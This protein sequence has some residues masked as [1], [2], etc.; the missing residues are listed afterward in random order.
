MPHR[1]R[2]SDDV[3]DR[4]LAGEASLAETQAVEAWLAADPGRARAV[5]LLRGDLTGTWDANEGWRRLNAR[6]VEHMTGDD[7]SRSRQPVWAAS[8]LLI[9]FA[10]L[11]LAV[12]FIAVTRS[13]SHSA[14]NSQA[15]Q[16]ATTAAAPGARNLVQLGEATAFLGPSTSLRYSRGKEEAEL[17]GAA[18]FTTLSSQSNLVVRAGNVIK[19]DGETQFVVRADSGRDVVIGA[20][21]GTIKV[22]G[23]GI[24]DTVT[25]SP[26]EMVRVKQGGTAAV[27]R[28]VDPAVFLG[29]AKLPATA[30]TQ[31]EN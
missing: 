10:L 29:W 20:I 15:M 16:W 12:G 1:S 18:L 3:L 28:D 31:R 8:P 23:P 7:S 25:L 24:R 4:Y 26:R 21:A 9:G 5:G 2:I 30:I 22:S 17:N 27:E 14:D 6:I 11:I 19:A 13:R